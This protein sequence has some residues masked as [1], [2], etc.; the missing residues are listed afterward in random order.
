M[1]RS[2]PGFTLIELMIVSAIIAVLIALL[3][4][5]IQSAREAAQ[6]AQCA[7]NLMQLGI[8]YGQLRVNPRGA[9]AGSRQ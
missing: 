4:P 8:A 3:L 6:R 9:P 7:N 5:A 1:S 2:K